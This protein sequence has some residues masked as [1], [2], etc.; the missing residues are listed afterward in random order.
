MY[1][2]KSTENM[3]ESVLNKFQILLKRLSSKQQDSTVRCLTYK[4]QHT[5]TSLLP[6]AV[7]Y[8]YIPDY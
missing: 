4:K 8:R 6:Y 7:F 5:A 3:P 1:G 2:C